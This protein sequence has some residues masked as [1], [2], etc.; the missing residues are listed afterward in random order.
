M[1]ETSA[2]YREMS[3][4]IARYAT[5]VGEVAT[6]IDSLFLSKRT[7]PSQPLYTAQWPCFALVAQGAK[8]LTLGQEVYDY[9]VGDY[10]VVALDLPVTSRTT[11]ASPEAPLFGLGMAIRP[12]RLKD[13]FQ[14]VPPVPTSATDRAR[15]VAVNQADEGLLNAVMRLLRLLEAPQDIRALAPLIEQEILYRL[16]TGPC[17]AA[18]TRIAQTDSPGNRVAKAVSWLRENYTE[19]L[20]IEELA[21]HVGMSTSS[22]HH[23]FSA[24]TAMTPL[25][26]QKRLRLQEARR[27]MWV[28]R[29]DVGSAGYRVGYQSPSQFSREYS[30]MFGVAPSRDPEDAHARLVISPAPLQSERRLQS[31]RAEASRPDLSGQTFSR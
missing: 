17:G 25:E 19:Q 27:L 1:S 10:L 2:V 6:A 12:E 13:L 30:R 7:E 24:V 3:G 5:D 21:G 4:L 22:L 14:R 26:Y 18:L 9:G 8:S 20:R 23:H 15:G 11:V 28:D 31:G 16:L 29:L